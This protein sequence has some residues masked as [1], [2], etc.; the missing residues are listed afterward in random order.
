MCLHFPSSDPTTRNKIYRAQQYM[1]RKPEN[2]PNIETWPLRIVL[3]R[4][5]GGCFVLLWN[6]GVP[7]GDELPYFFST[8]I[9][10]ILMGQQ[11][12]VK[13]V[14]HTWPRLELLYIPS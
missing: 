2:T 8:V 5:V 10:T 1:P 9:G 13:T 4:L 14:R 11:H 7:P 12:T 6:L 3:I